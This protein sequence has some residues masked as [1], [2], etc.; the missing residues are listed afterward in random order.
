MGRMLVEAANYQI[1]N[2]VIRK[3][4]GSTI[5]VYCIDVLNHSLTNIVV[6]S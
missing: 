6:I 1:K 2:D 3:V 5:V 4:R